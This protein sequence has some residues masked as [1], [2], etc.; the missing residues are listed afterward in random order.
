L[1]FELGLNKPVPKDTHEVP[2]LKEKYSMA[3]T[4]RTMEERRAVLGCFLVSSMYALRPIYLQKQALIA[5][6]ISSFLQ[7]I[8]ALRWTPHMD[9]SLQMLGQRKEC[10]N[11]EILVQQVRLQLIVEQMARGTLHDGAMESIEH[12]REPLSL[13]LRTAHSQLQDIKTKLLAQPQTDG[14]LLCTN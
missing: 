13:C 4:P 6:R 8:D 3:T 5:F 14:K 10:Y 11:D 9:E 1:V 2:C 12:A 7:K